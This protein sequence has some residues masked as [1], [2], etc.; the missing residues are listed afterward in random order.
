MATVNGEPI[1]LDEFN[2]ELA[3]IHQGIGKDKKAEKEKISRL[4]KRLINMRLII[5][6][7]RRMGLDELKE[8]KER[9]D[10]FAAE[11]P[12]RRIGRKTG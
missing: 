6:E 12:S 9:V 11:S 3:T 7:A 1:T 8:V 5:Q 2:R 4:L 10:V